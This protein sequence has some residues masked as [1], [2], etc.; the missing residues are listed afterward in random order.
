MDSHFAAL[1]AEGV[2]V[3]RLDQQHAFIGRKHSGHPVVTKIDRGGDLAPAY[4]LRVAHEAAGC[5]GV[6]VM[7][8]DAARIEFER[9]YVSLY[10]RPDRLVSSGA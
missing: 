6:V 7:G 8:P 4:L 1:M 10:R 2:A 9:Q 3:I 5:D